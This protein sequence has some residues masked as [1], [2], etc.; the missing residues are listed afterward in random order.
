[1]AKG[2]KRI[3]LNEPLFHPDHARP[4]T[5]REFIAQGFAT[6]VATVLGGPLLNMLAASRARAD[7]SPLAYVES[8]LSVRLPRA[9]GPVR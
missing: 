5:R 4:R 8:P 9:R 6:G 1:M 2:R 7:L 3:G